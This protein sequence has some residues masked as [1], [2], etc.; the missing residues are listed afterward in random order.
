MEDAAVRL[1]VQEAVAAALIAFQAAQAPAA[2]AAVVPF[3]V[4]PAGAGADPFNFASPAGLKVFVL[5]TAPIDPIFG[6]EQVLLNDFLRKIW[7]R[8]E[9]YGFTSILMVNDAAGRPRNLTREFGCISIAD[10]RAAG[11]AVLRIEGRDHQAS[12]ML[13]QLV[14]ASITP[15]LTD[16][17]L[18]QQDKYTVDAAAIPA[19]GA[20]ANLPV[21]MEYGPA[22]LLVLILMVSVETRATVSTI[23]AKLNNLEVLMEASK[24]NVEV[25]NI[26]V[27]KLIAGLRARNAPVPDLLTNLFSGYRNC[28]DK[29]FTEY[30]DR[31]EESY[32]DGTIAALTAV[33]LM[34]LALE[35]FKGLVGKGLWMVKSEDELQLVAMRAELHQI[36]QNAHALL[37]PPKE[38]T[39]KSG[40]GKDRN[41]KSKYAWKN[42]APKG[43][44]PHHKTFGG[45]KYIHC[46]HHEKTC[47]V[48]ETNREGIL[49]KTG[50]RKMAEA[51]GSQDSTAPA[52][53]A[54]TEKQRRLAA[55]LVSVMDEDGDADNEEDSN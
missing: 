53:F 23:M 45:K 29:A 17:L 18:L 3:A 28:G 6:G 43:N 35:K 10:V 22:M 42:V 34:Q 32:E 19:V 27:G 31:K 54:A 7:N 11:A 37:K 5:V 21:L 9:T 15:E 39:G 44:E 48:L 50:C 20:A 4:T 24:S 40:K 30:M 36:R 41:D 8:A 13:R 12:V 49:H 51:A 14:M 16:R 52:T 47:W 33:D 55:A 26:E 38:K 1:L 25:F 2:A 46:P